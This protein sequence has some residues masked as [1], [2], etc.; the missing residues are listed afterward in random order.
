MLDQMTWPPPVLAMGP[1]PDGEGD[2]LPGSGVRGG[3]SSY[4]SSSRALPSGDGQPALTPIKIR[5]QSLS[6]TRTRT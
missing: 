5:F 1:A 2:S 3:Q 6:K 4:R